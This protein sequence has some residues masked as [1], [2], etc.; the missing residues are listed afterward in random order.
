MQ[1]ISRRKRHENYDLT[2]QRLQC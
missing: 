2:L 1:K